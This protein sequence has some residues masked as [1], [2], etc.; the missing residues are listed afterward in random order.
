[1]PKE[2]ARELI[3]IARPARYGLGEATL[4][5]PRVRDTWE[6]PKSRVKIDQ[7]RWNKTLLPVL[8]QLRADLALPDAC[9]L[10]AELHSMLVYAP[11]QFFAPHQDTE[12][13]DGMVGSLVVTLP[14]RFTGGGL[15]V[16]HGAGRATVRSSKDRLSFVAFYADCRHEI[17]PVRSGYR[18]VLTYN[19]SVR[20]HIAGTPPEIA[21]AELDALAGCLQ[22]HFTT[23]APPP[24]WQRDDK[25]ARPPDRLVYLLDHEYTERSLCGAHLKG[26]DALR[27]AALRGAAELAGCE[28]VLALADISESWSAYEREPYGRHS[29]RSRSGHW[30]NEDDEDDEDDDEVPGDEYEL[31]EL[32]ESSISLDHWTDWSGKRAERIVSS[33]GDDEVCAMTPTDQ[34]EP[35]GSAYEPY[36]G[37]Y[38]NTLDRQ[39]RRAALVLWPRDRAFAVRAEA[40][41]IWA[42]DE[43]AMRFKS[44]AIDQ[45]RQLARMLEPFWPTAARDD[46]PSLFGRALR[47]AVGLDDPEMAAALL[48]PF[49]LEMITKNAAASLAGLADH[50]PDQWLAAVVAQWSGDDRRWATS[51]DRAAWVAA[52][53]PLCRAL[54]ARGGAGTTAALLLVD[55]AHQWLAKQVESRCRVQR[56]SLRDDTLD[57]LARPLLG[58]LTSTATLCVPQVRDEVVRLVC[59]HGDDVLLPLLTGMARAAS[60][61]QA[62]ERV[63]AGV[64]AVTEHCLHLLEARLAR[65]PRAADDWSILLPDGCGCE[66]CG[67][68]RTFLA[69]PTQRTRDWPLAQDRR[70]HVHDRIDASELPVRHQTRRSGRPYTLVLTKTSDLFDREEMQ[71]RRDEADVRWLR[72]QLRH[73]TSSKS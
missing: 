27:A 51:G 16:A 33:V 29:W 57:Q 55:Q 3:R 12:K 11:G 58:L 61:L 13:S 39:Y 10:K 48:A 44:G 38:G 56:T 22:E 26:A 2:Q 64:D 66:L 17:R 8:D 67:T 68:L 71:R 6:V 43:V 62:Q 32:I 18:I 52:L 7:R 70:R 14:A 63:D 72:T 73:H 41:P 25:P 53:P 60:K 20:G 21:P 15:V 69:D 28:V 5:D 35:Y 30:E 45:A 40:S 36:M 23:A 37:N 47:V 46:Q 19:L 42:L 65:P 1:M 59:R 31:E 4:L 9:R 24:S 49:R 50:Y 54:H 34:F